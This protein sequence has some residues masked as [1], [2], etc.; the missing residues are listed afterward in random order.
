MNLKYRNKIEKQFK[1]FQKK[2]NTTNEELCKNLP[3]EFL[4]FVQYIKD[5]HFEEKPNYKYLER[6][7][8]KIYNKINCK[9]DTII[10]YNNIVNIKN[11]K[12][13]NNDNNKKSFSQIQNYKILTKY[14]YFNYSI[15]K[16]KTEKKN[17]FYI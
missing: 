9:Y 14:N 6:L 10:K 15:I 11:E 16:E 4:T 13:G 17:F 5:L 1:I 12:T 7:L 3:N 8:G 2:M